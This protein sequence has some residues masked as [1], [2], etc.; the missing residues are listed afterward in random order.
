MM[1]L[2]GG[3]SPSQ[4]A[5]FDDWTNHMAVAEAS[6]RL[7]RVP[8]THSHHRIGKPASAHTSPTTLM[9]M[10][11]ATRRTHDYFAQPHQQYRP[12]NRQAVYSSS[13]SARPVSWHPSSYMASNPVTY[14][15]MNQQQHHHSQTPSCYP[16]STPTMYDAPAYADAPEAAAAYPS[17]SPM[18]A[19]QS[20]NV[21]PCSTFSMPPQAFNPAGQYMS[22]DTWAMQQQQQQHR[23]QQQNSTPYFHQAD[24]LMMD[25]QQQQ[26]PSLTPAESTLDWNE[27][28]SAS[29][30]HAM[31]GTTP[32]TPETYPMQQQQQAA[33]I[34]PT[35]TTAAG[36]NSV[37]NGC[38]DDEDG[39]ILVGMGLYDFDAPD[40][41]SREDPQLDNYRSTM[42]SLLGSTYEYS[43]R[44]QATGKGLTLE[45][46]WEP[47]KSD[48]EDEDADADE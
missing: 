15:A 12:G 13:S 41:M 8:S 7:S 36:A 20:T 27:D 42:S 1:T 10:T 17:L 22:P 18:E 45:Q 26:P 34:I 24:G 30:Q 29:L 32:P 37:D 43:H 2:N 23:A 47:P 3:Y 21:S 19:C 46:A 5:F 4:N 35:A 39:E 25:Q 6:R 11:P 44:S 9:S 40:K 48:D 31:A 16:L 33:A 28:P 14:P 38:N